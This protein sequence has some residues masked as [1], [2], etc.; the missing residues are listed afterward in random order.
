V[1]TVTNEQFDDIRYEIDGPTAVVTIARPERYNAFR[2]RTVEELVAA[3]RAAWADRSVRAIIFTGEGDK[4][5][6]SGGDVKQR[7][8]TG[9]YGRP[10]AATPS[11]SSRPTAR[12]TSRARC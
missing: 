10:R 5:F 3:F 1:T 12:A 6:C 2:G 11:S 8:E 4:A 9:D 7:A